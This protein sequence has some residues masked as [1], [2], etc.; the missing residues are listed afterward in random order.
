M[1]YPQL[2]T[3]IDIGSNRYINNV[4]MENAENEQDTGDMKKHKSRALY[5]NNEKKILTSQVKVLRAILIYG[6]KR[7]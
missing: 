1:I 2:A 7:I 4:L 6:K 3:I 5:W